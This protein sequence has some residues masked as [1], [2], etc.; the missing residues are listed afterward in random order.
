ML[1]V[2]YCDIIIKLNSHW[3]LKF[4]FLETDQAGG[5]KYFENYYI[6]DII[7]EKGDLL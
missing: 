5:Y 3:L 7:N 1:L 2:Y 4:N 6:Y